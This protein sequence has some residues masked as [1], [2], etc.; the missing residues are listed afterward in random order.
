MSTLGLTEPML[1]EVILRSSS[2]LQELFHQL[3]FWTM[4]ALATR[5]GAPEP[6]RYDRYLARRA[7]PGI[8]VGVQPSSDLTAMVGVVILSW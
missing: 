2:S 1:S 3:N 4:T 5:G 7:I 6:L 8:Y